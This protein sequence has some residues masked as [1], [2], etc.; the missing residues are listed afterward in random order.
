MAKTRM[1]KTDLRTS[2]KVA[3]WPIELRYFW[4]LLWGYVDDHGKARDNPLLVKADCFPLDEAITR[5]TV[6]RWLWD[7]TSAGVVVRYTAGDTD[8]LAVRNWSEHQKP[9]HPTGD[10]LPRWDASGAVIREPHASFM[11][12]SRKGREPLTPELSRDG[13]G[14]GSAVEKSAHHSVGVTFEEFWAVWGKRVARADAERAWAK[15]VKVADPMAIVLAAQAL[16][17]SPHRPEKQY[18]P[19]PATWLNREQWNDPAPEPP[20][21]K[22]G[23]QG[24]AKADTNFAEYERLYGSGDGRAR[25]VPAIDPGVR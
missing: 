6:D 19:Y 21:S 22:G 23:R 15:A 1:L 8:Y 25:S 5:A 13:F 9:Q 17:E 2:E 7:L 18:I 24:V 10:V 16:W 4:V 20:E 11:K 3:S 12:S 14:F